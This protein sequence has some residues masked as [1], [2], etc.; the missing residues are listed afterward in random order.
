M[1]AA[2]LYKP[3]TPL[4][5]VDVEQ[6]PPRAGEARVRVMATG[7]CHSDWHI[8]NGDWA[9]PLPVVLGHEAAGLV[10]ETGAGVTAVRPGDHVIFSFRPHCGRCFYCT[11]GRTILCDGHT[12]ERGVMLDGT[13]R[14]RHKGQGIYQMGR[15][16]TF[17]ERVVCPAEM[18]VPIR[19]EMPWAQA[20]LVG[21][22]VPTGVGA[23]TRCAQVEAGASVVVIGCGGVGLNVVQGARLAGAATIVACDL[24]DSKLALAREFGATH[25]VNASRADLAAEVRKLTAG[26]GAD[27]AFDAIGGEQTTLQIVDAIRPGG[28]AVIVGMAPQATRAPITPFM[29]AVQ[30]KVL[31]GTMYGSVRPDVDFPWLVDLYLQGRLK[32]DELVSRRWRLDEINEGFAAMRSG[33]VARG[34]VVF[35]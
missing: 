27:Y 14:L 3:N 10:E 30:E 9:S 24:L 21:C 19:P 12:A 17:S 15:I 33:Q 7:V 16:G 28:T 32:I 35:G 22:C 18:L 26:R 11:T 4:E 13:F 34:V 23:V 2:V 20:A 6:E 31:K 5:V 8:A 29:M 1:N 25:T